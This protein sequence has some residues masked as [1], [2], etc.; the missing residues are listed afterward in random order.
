[1]SFNLTKDDM[2][3]P[4]KSAYVLCLATDA[5]YV[6][7]IGQYAYVQQVSCLDYGCSVD[8]VR[9]RNDL[10]L[11]Q[12]TSVSPLVFYKVDDKPYDDSY[13]YQTQANLQILGQRFLFHKDQLED[14][15]FP[16]DD[17]HKTCYSKFDGSWK[18]TIFDFTQI[19]ESWNKD[20]IPANSQGSIIKESS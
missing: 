11:L 4:L 8:A 6:P 16:S 10:F 7:K 12:V 14:F 19:D 13:W 20:N 18:K 17:S 9:M 2:F 3:F 1:M 5:N 15:Q